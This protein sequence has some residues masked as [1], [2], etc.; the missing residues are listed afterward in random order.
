MTVNP[1]HAPGEWLKAALHT[2]STVSDGT[3]PPHRLIQ[4]Y[5]EAGF[6]VVAITDHWR[7]TE[8]EGTDRVLTVRGAELGWDIQRPNYPGQSAEFLVYGLDHI[9]PDPGGD[10]RNLSTTITPRIEK[11]P[12]PHI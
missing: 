10:R 2:H 11:C 8:V 4:A 6:D 3:L 9:P 12:F 5:D 1:F 7:L